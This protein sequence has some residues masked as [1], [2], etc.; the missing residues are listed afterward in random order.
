MIKLIVFDID[1]TLVDDDKVLS[2]RTKGVLCA[3]KCQGVRLG[4]ASGRQVKQYRKQVKAWGLDFEFD[5]YIGLNGAEMLDTQ[6]EEYRSFYK[7]KISEVKE[8]MEVMKPYVRHRYYKHGDMIRYD[9]DTVAFKVR[10]LEDCFPFDDL[11]ELGITEIGKL[12]YRYKLDEVQKIED[13]IIEN[14]NRKQKDYHGFKTQP[15]YLEF[16]NIHTSKAIPMVYYADKYGI[17]KDEIMALGDTTNDNTMI[18]A[19]GVGVCLKNGTQDTKDIADIVTEYTNNEEGA[20]HF[21]KSYFQ[22]K[23]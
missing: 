19:S 17:V 21:L 6:D 22:I 4:L 10:E 20:Y 12:L 11:E 8:I 18:Q 16:S 15:E 14:I 9:D 2:E 23:K 5:L 1:G 13:F 3:L 7:L